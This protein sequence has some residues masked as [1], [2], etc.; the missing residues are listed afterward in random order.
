MNGNIT[1]TRKPLLKIL[2]YFLTVA[3]IISLITANTSAQLP[4]QQKTLPLP[5]FAGLSG[6]LNQEKPSAKQ[7]N[8][9]QLHSIIIKK[10]DSLSR[11]F[12]RIG[13]ADSVSLEIKKTKN[14]KLLTR[15]NVNDKLNIWVNDKNKLQ[16]IIL[17]KNKIKFI[18]LTK[19]NDKFIIKTI[20]KDVRTII[21]T[22]SG[23]INESFYL[24]GLTAGLSPKI[25][26]SLSDIFSWEI[27]FIRQLRKNDP[28]KVIYEKKYIDGEYVGDGDILAAEITT[29][30]KNKNYAFLLR[31]KNLKN[32]GYYDEKGRNLR[33][34]FLK[35]PVDYVRITSHFT[36]RRYH[37]VLHK[38]RSHRGVDY[39]GATG[40]PIRSTGDGQIIKRGWSNSYGRVIYVKHANKYT[41]VYAH[42][43]RYGKYKKWQ[44]VKQGDV[45]GYIG[46]TGLATGPH[47]HYEFRKNGV[48]IDPL[49][50]K[51]PDAGPVPKKYKPQFMQFAKIMQTQLDRNIYQ[52][53]LVGNF[54]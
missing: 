26:M 45:I 52:V 1:K 28:F 10:N 15:L 47:L 37:P 9:W 32:I 11:V 31:D 5:S 42:M 30:H 16:K 12:S 13:L 43:S 25:I 49:N 48:H 29:N 53:K 39:A 34:A 44:W 38:W 17:P 40:T 19:E 6:E 2:L 7:T 21:T 20:E 41:T 46:A 54:E 23:R 36:P 8:N 24:S 27:D 51:F 14:S 3:M 4:P 22:V 50:T 33:K 18:I 35:S